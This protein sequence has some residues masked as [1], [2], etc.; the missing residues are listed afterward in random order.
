MGWTHNITDEQPLI[1]IAPTSVHPLDSTMALGGVG[2]DPFNP[3]LRLAA[4]HWIFVIYRDVLTSLR[5]VG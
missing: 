3:E 1:K 4:P 5:G 2:M